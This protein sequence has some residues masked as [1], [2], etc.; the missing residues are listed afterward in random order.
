MARTLDLVDI[1]ALLES[2][3]I[4]VAR[5]AYVDSAENA[6]VFANRRPISMYHLRPDGRGYDPADGHVDVLGDDAIRKAYR[7]LTAKAGSRIFAQA[8]VEAGT[9]I[10][11]AGYK[12]DANKY[13]R[14]LAGSHQIE[15]FCPLS[16][17]TAEAMLEDVGSG[18]SIASSEHARRM[19]AHLFVKASEMFEESTIDD[20]VLWIRVHDNGYKVIDAQMTADRIPEIAHHAGKHAHD[21]W[22]Y[23]YHPAVRPSLE[24]H[25]PDRK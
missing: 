23:D 12:R 10:R 3:G 11:L 13:I 6:I 21:R 5:S 18:R 2:Y 19:L 15:R 22:S 25:T 1:L 9:G 7:S 20:F 16:D 14:L 24:P 8:E 17:D 4:A